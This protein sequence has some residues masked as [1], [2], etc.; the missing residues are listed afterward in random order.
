MATYFFSFSN[1]IICSFSVI[2]HCKLNLFGFGQTKQAIWRHHLTVRVK[3]NSTFSS[4]SG[5]ASINSSNKNI[6]STMLIIAHIGYTLQI[7]S[8]N[9]ERENTSHFSKAS[10]TQG[11]VSAIPYYTLTWKVFIQPCQVSVN[12]MPWCDSYEKQVFPYRRFETHV[13]V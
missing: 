7:Y 1:V 13:Q 4:G 10:F 6:F 11:T 12:E 5:T 2:Y 8:A 9:N 3:T